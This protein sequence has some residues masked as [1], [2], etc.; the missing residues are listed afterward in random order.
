VSY[1]DERPASWSTYDRVASAAADMR[2]L[3]FEMQ[4]GA[5]VLG[6]LVFAKR[7]GDT[8]PSREDLRFAMGPLNYERARE[9]LDCV[10]LNVKKMGAIALSFATTVMAQS[11]DPAITS[12]LARVRALMAKD[13][14]NAA[15]N[16][17]EAWTCGRELPADDAD[18]DD[19]NK[20]ANAPEG[21]AR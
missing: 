1:D 7:V 9:H 20:E 5:H 16:L 8:K 6:P 18:D 15:W 12:I 17:V 14:I 19:N 2:F 13:D 21:P 3:M 11:T 4:A 10:A